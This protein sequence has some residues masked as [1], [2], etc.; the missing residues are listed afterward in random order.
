MCMIKVERKRLYTLEMKLNQEEM[1]ALSCF[2][3]NVTKSDCRAV[4]EGAKDYQSRAETVY[5]IFTAIS[6]V[7][8][9]DIY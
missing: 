9:D 6:Q 1:N 5:A 4:M 7:A 8:A 2:C 3:L